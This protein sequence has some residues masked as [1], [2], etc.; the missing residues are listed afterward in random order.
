MTAAIWAAVTCENRARCAAYFEVRSGAGEGRR[1]AGPLAGSPQ[2]GA[3]APPTPAAGAGGPGMRL[4]VAPRRMP[5]KT[6][7]PQRA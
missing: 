6:W 5:M 4:C 7:Q 1:A 2:G 3:F